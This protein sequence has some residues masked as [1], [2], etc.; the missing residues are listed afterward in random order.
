[1]EKFKNR[2][3]I[4]PFRLRSWD[5][6]APGLYFITICTHKKA[7]YFGKIIFALPPEI[8]HPPYSRDTS[9]LSPSSP[10]PPGK[11]ADT[12]PLSRTAAIPRGSLSSPPPPG[13]NA[14][15]PPRLPPNHP[16]LPKNFDDNAPESRGIATLRG[17]EIGMMAEKYWW[18]IPKY[19]PYV[20][21]DEF[22]VMPNHVHGIIIIDKKNYKGWRP[23]KFGPQS[24]N[25]ASILRGYKSAVT[26]YARKNN[27]EFQWH[28]KYHDRIIRNKK[29]LRNIRN[30]IR[31][32]PHNW[33]KKKFRK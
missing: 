25:L 6:G 27:I 4:A 20:R 16:I 33:M 11:N 10:P 12:P 30:Y 31:R 28:P 15:T 13:K 7:H 19:H 2:Y 23:N 29:A 9:R 21:L 8:P 18:D 17:T 22:V 5:Y 32:N 3:R 14:D 24:Q 26:T 1:M